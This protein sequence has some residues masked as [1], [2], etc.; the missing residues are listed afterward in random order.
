MMIYCS[1]LALINTELQGKSKLNSPDAI[2]PPGGERDD[3]GVNFTLWPLK[4][5][6]NRAN[7]NNKTAS[8]VLFL[9]PST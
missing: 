4:F 2:S 8:I 6:I 5:C 1:S 7:D 3:L 9:P